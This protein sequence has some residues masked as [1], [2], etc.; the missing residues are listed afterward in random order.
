MIKMRIRGKVGKRKKKKVDKKTEV[1]FIQK[2]NFT[3]RY[4]RKRA[5]W[6]VPIAHSFSTGE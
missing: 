3:R 6:A 2:H 5:E 4:L 1:A